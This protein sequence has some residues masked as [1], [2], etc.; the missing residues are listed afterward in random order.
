MKG[1]LCDL[2]LPISPLYP[3]LCVIHRYQS[4]STESNAFKSKLLPL[5]GPLLLLKAVGF[6]KGE[7]EDEG[8]LKFE[9]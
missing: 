6:Q 4:I 7:G 5:V 9:G 3:P 1:S 8:K 2:P